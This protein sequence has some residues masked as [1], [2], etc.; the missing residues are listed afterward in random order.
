MSNLPISSPQPSRVDQNTPLLL[1]RSKSQE[2]KPLSASDPEDRNSDSVLVESPNGQ[3]RGFS[4]R[5]SYRSFAAA[6]SGRTPGSFHDNGQAGDYFSASSPRISRLSVAPILENSGSVA[7]DH[8]ALE[9][10][11]LAY[12][13]TSLTMTFAGVALAQLLTLSERLQDELHL[14]LDP[15]ETYARPVA[16]ASICLGLFV[17]CVGV[18][19]YFSVQV[20]LTNGV[21]PVTRYRLA[22]ITVGLGAIVT[23]IFGM[24]M[25]EHVV[26]KS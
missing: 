17:L 14:I 24:L 11:F 16:A 18:S 7:R 21:F 3:E 4:S 10:T 26:Q 20:A 2:N 25:A 6:I 22:M 9:R 13:R 15:F 19:R 5:T 12:V 1:S 8:L 23:A